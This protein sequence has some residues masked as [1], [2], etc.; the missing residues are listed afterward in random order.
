MP[1]YYANKIIPSVQE[2]TK[3]WRHQMIAFCTNRIMKNTQI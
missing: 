3:A 1:L 2:M